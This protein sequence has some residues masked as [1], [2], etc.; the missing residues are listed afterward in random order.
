MSAILAPL[1]ESE[2]GLNSALR[3]RYFIECIDFSLLQ[4]EFDS[5]PASWACN[6]LHLREDA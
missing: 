3:L 5:G 1:G 6:L 4:A 2:W